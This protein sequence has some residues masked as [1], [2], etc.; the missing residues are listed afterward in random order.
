MRSCG[1]RVSVYVCEEVCEGFWN[2]ERGGGLERF[3]GNREKKRKRRRKHF[4]VLACMCVRVHTSTQA[5]MYMHGHE[6]KLAVR[7]N[8]PTRNNVTHNNFAARLSYNDRGTRIRMY[9]HTQ[10]PSAPSSRPFLATPISFI[11]APQPPIQR[12]TTPSLPQPPVLSRTHPSTLQL[13]RSCFS[14]SASKK[15]RNH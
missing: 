8:S 14:S 3:L 10:I 2:I 15:T 6:H 7:T 4:L 13:S 12:L 9:T 11:Q 5:R 1:L